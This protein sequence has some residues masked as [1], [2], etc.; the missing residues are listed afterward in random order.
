MDPATVRFTS[1]DPLAE[2]YYSISPYVYVANNPLKFID[3]DGK[4]PIDA[5]EDA[6]V[7]QAWGAKIGNYI[8]QNRAEIA[9]SVINF[10]SAGAVNRAERELAFDKTNPSLSQWVAFQQRENH[11]E[12]FMNWMGGEYRGSNLA[13]NYKVDLFGGE[14]SSSK[15]FIN[16]DKVAK[17]GIADDIANFGKHFEKNSISEMVVNNPQAKF[18]KN[19]LSSLQKGSKVTIRGGMSNPNFNTIWNEKA[20]GLESFLIKKKTE[21]VPNIGYYRND[22]VTPVR[23]IINEIILEKK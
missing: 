5:R 18:L 15:G 13:K 2:E 8:K 17:E 14:R 1:V 21:G 9:R 22:G 11:Q 19:V 4:Q 3:P 12:I 6:L 23:G 10:I 16:F 7:I 20:A